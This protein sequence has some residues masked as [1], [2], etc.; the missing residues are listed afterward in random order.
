MSQCSLGFAGLRERRG[1]GVRNPGLVWAGGILGDD[2]PEQ[3]ERSLARYL[4]A[5]EQQAAEQRLR[6]MVALVG[7]QPQPARR[8]DGVLGR[9]F[10]GEV[11]LAE[12]VLGLG[13]GEIRGGIAE[14]LARDVGIGLQ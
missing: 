13:I 1:I 8:L 3:A 12:I 11:E 10:A 2:Q 14:H 6:A 5:L 7:G 4:L 9:A